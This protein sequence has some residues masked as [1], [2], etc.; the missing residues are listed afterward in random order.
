MVEWQHTLSQSR[1]VTS[2]V[3]DWNAS[4]V[5]MGAE[6]LLLAVGAASTSGACGEQGRRVA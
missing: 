2:T 1:K 6:P 3:P 5:L 4:C